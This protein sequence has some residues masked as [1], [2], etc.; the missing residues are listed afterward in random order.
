MSMAG[1]SDWFPAAL[2]VLVVDDCRTSVYLLESMLK[3]C[4]YEVKK[5]CSGEAALSLLRENQDG[6]DI[7]ISEIHLPVPDMDG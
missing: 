2:R 6:Y 4:L 5:C 3:R 7:I 1:H